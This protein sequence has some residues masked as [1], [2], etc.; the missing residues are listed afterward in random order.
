MIDYPISILKS[1]KKYYE[2]KKLKTLV[3]MKR[4]KIAFRKWVE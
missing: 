1:K 4:Y 3:F 2:K